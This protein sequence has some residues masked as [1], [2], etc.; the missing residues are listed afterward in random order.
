MIDIQNSFAKMPSR[1]PSTSEAK[2]GTNSSQLAVGSGPSNDHGA[3][4]VH[5]PAVLYPETTPLND[6]YPGSA[7]EDEEDG[8]GNS[9]KN[10]RNGNSSQPSG[11]TRAERAELPEGHHMPNNGSTSAPGSAGGRF[12]RISR[13][14][15][16][17]RPSY[18]VVTIGSGYGGAVAASRMARG[19]KSV[20]LLER[21]RE[22]WPGEFPSAGLSAF[23]ELHVT[24]AATEG[25]SGRLARH[26]P[27]DEG[28]PTGL[29]H[30]IVGDGQNCFVGNGLGGTSLLN[31]NVFLEAD[32]KV[33]K[34]P[35]WPRELHGKEKWDECKSSVRRGRRR[36]TCTN[37]ES[38]A[39]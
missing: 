28:D 18:D 26:V 30:L 29:Y 24:N 31:A 6:R 16:L 32:P 37:F 3:D 14:V 27:R 15:E 25:I 11:K 35:M 36:K 9:P 21:G 12:P 2:Q 1:A 13:P 22:R 39:P 7:S 38:P 4:G 34:M 8:A 20:C 17:I 19:G 5:A 23:K 10:L 33:L